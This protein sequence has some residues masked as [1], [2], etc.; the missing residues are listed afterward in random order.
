MIFK[1]LAFSIKKKLI[2]LNIIIEKKNPIFLFIYIL[3][4]IKKTI[5]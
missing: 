3:V 5:L 1:Y 4:L 2:F